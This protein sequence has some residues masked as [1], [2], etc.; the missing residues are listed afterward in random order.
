MLFLQHANQVRFNIIL[1]QAY[2]F[3]PP[4]HIDAQ[5]YKKD[6]FKFFGTVLRRSNFWWHSVIP[7]VHWSMILDLILTNCSRLRSWNNTWCLHLMPTLDAYTW[8]LHLMP[9]LDA[10]TWCLHLMHTSK[11]IQDN[12]EKIWGQMIQM[13]SN[14]RTWRS[15]VISSYTSWQITA[16]QVML[17]PHIHHDKSQ[18][19]RSCYILIYIMTNHSK[20]GHVISSYTSW[21]ITANQPG[22]T[23]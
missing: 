15:D 14:H 23:T 17:Y 16:N 5:R 20:S 3:M 22:P 11:D 19:I 21:Q 6:C 1:R 12:E 4:E 13:A 2:F 9:T 10:Y 8:C 7:R 18:Q